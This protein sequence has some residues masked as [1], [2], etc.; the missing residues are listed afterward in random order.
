M[1]IPATVFSVLNSQNTQQAF[2]KSFML[3]RARSNL[4]LVRKDGG[5]AYFQDDKEKFD[6]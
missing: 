4:M 5:V 6:C 2:K 1:V 3:L